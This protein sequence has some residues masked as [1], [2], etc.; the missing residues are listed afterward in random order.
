MFLNLRDH[1]LTTINMLHFRTIKVE[2]LNK[3]FGS[4][5]RLNMLS[6]VLLSED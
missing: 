5:V 2:N 1:T 3:K 6:T 4:A